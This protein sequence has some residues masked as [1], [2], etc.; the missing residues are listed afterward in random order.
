MIGRGP[1]VSG[2][3]CV[4]VAVAAFIAAP[5]SRAAYSC[6]QQL[7]YAQR[8]IGDPNAPNPH[9]GI[10]AK[11]VAAAEAALQEGDEARCL[12]ALE[13]AQVWIR[14]RSRGGHDR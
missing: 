12:E 1:R 8:H 13:K 4:A 14:M 11:H 3:C 10:A 5:E 6:A 9:M 2:L 7:P